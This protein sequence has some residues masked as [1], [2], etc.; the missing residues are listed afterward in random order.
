MLRNY[1][2]RQRTK[3]EAT[4]A[5][6][7]LEPWEKILSMFVFM[8][9]ALLLVSGLYQYLPQHV[10]IMRQRA[11][12]YLWGEDGEDRLL[13]HFVDSSTLKEL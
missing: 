4:L 5:F 2:W 1:L 8:F 12:Y 10:S 9:F 3:F 6:S 11:I 13:R 7:M